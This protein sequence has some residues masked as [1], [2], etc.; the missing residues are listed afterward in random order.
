MQEAKIL[1]IEDDTDIRESLADILT[2]EGHD[3]AT[4]G[5]GQEA[6]DYLTNH[7]DETPDLILLDLMMPIMDGDNFLL[8]LES[9]LPHIKTPIIILSAAICGK[10]RTNVVTFMKK[11]VDLD[12]LLKNVQKY[13]HRPMERNLYA[14]QFN[15]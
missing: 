15:S 9:H 6:F 13:I 5:N 10:E 14:I 11:P 2:F 4:A 7:P 1:I 3:V 12:N 8:K